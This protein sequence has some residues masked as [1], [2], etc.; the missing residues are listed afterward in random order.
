MG[1][2]SFAHAIQ[3]ISHFSVGSMLS[4]LGYYMVLA[5]FGILLS[6]FLGLVAYVVI[7]FIRR[8][9]EMTP[10]QFILFMAAFGLGLIVVGTLLPG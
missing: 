9:G 5:G 7:K 10:L 6:I 8:I 2:E 3:T 1:V 4:S